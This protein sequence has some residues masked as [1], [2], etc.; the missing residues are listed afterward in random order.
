MPLPSGV[1]RSEPSSASRGGRI[2]ASGAPA[3]PRGWPL[4]HIPACRKRAQRRVERVQTAV[5]L[6]VERAFA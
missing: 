2:P 1:V 4:F 6:Q 5:W 3:P